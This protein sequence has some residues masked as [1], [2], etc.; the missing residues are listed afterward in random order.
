MSCHIV[1]TD[2]ASS[3]L[4][5]QHTRVLSDMITIFPA[6]Q[7]LRAFIVLAIKAVLSAYVQSG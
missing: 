5:E 4:Y 7:L 3:P 1:H 2:L 6:C